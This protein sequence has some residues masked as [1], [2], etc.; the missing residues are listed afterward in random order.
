MARP[1]AGKGPKAGKSGNFK[2]QTSK[3]AGA[4]GFSGGRAQSSGPAQAVAAAAAAAG[5]GFFSCLL[6]EIGNIKTWKNNQ[7]GA[8]IHQK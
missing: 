7:K 3:K 1:P 2:Q 6:L 4:G 5:K 8:K